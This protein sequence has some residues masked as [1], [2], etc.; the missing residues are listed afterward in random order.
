VP[1]S[2]RR[3]NAARQPRHSSGAAIPPI[4]PLILPP[5]APAPSPAPTPPATGARGMNVG[6]RLIKRKFN[7]IIVHCFLILNINLHWIST[8]SIWSWS[9]GHDS[10]MHPKSPS[11]NDLN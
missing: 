8:S 1:K 9:D 6:P 10:D 2:P 5:P 7:Y 4:K 3:A 11:N